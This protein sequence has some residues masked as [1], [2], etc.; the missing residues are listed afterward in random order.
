MRCFLLLCLLLP[1]T[2]GSAASFDDVTLVKA[3][4]WQDLSLPGT[5]LQE[6]LYQSFSEADK[7]LAGWVV[8]MKETQPEKIDPD[9]ADLIEDLNKAVED[10]K[11]RGFDWAEYRD[12]RNSGAE[13]VNPAVLEKEVNLPGFLLPVEGKENMCVLVPWIGNAHDPP[14][15]ANQTVL[16]TVPVEMKL[17]HPSRPV[18]ASGILQA[19]PATSRV[20][21]E[22]GSI[23]MKTAYTM[24]VTVVRA[25][26][27]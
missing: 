6:N 22:A 25:Y 12:V 20:R 1:A 27:E 16:V 4:E 8:Y 18:F 13:K 7:G 26:E 21:L 24:N 2:V 15:P 19:G 14:P 23:E 5:S 9:D 11:A 3:V 10:F 17:P